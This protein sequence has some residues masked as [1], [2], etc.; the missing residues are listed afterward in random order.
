[1]RLSTFIPRSVLLGFCAA[2]LA[3]ASPVPAHAGGEHAV[4]KVEA[5]KANHQQPNRAKRIRAALKAGRD[6]IRLKNLP[7]LRGKMWKQT[8]KITA[9]GVQKI[10]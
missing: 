3:L 6:A 4:M 1:M 2:S 5:T 8:K 9:K 10:A 7:Q